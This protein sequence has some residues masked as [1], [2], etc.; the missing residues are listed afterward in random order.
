MGFVKV[1]STGQQKC[2]DPAGRE[3]PCSGTIQDAAIQSGRPWPT[4]RFAI[5]D[6]KQGIH[7]P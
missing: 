5:Q 3:I 4:D 1:L 2:Y 6:E 7:G